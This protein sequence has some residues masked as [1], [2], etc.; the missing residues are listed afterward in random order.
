MI[1]YFI[2]TV[3][4]LSKMEKRLKGMLFTVY[5][6]VHVYRLWGQVASDLY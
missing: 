4:G 6:Y 2:L 1:Q 3:D 5:V